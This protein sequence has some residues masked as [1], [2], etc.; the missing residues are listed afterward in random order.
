M[1]VDTN[2][3]KKSGDHTMHNMSELQ[4]IR[5]LA[6]RLVESQ[7]SVLASIDWPYGAPPKVGLYQP[8]IFAYNAIEKIIYEVKATENFNTGEL[9]NR[10]RE[11]DSM[12]SSGIKTCLVLP[13]SLGLNISNAKNSLQRNKLFDVQIISCNPQR[14]EIRFH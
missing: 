2:F 6:E 13:S 8:D 1:S 12:K 9:L 5:F 10:L 3:T 11:F 7:Y 14:N 4:I